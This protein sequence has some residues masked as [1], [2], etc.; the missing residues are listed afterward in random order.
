[1][2]FKDGE[3]NPKCFPK[4]LDVLLGCTLAFKVR[5]QPNN[6]SSSVMKASNNLE[7]I[8]SIRSKLETKMV[9]HLFKVFKFLYCSQNNFM[10]MKYI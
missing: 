7:T 1:L 6:K 5:V 9:T 2:F 4:D 8:T 3:D 10:K